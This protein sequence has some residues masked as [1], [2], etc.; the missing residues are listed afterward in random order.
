MEHVNKDIDE[1]TVDILQGDV[2]NEQLDELAANGELRKNVLVGQDII[3]GL[4]RQSESIDVEDRLRRFH[5]THLNR[6]PKRRLRIAAAAIVAVAAAVA[7]LLLIPA[8]NNGE[9]ERME[10]AHFQVADNRQGGIS[11]TNHRGE[12]VVLASKTQQNTSLTLD[13]F[14][15]VFSD[16]EGREDITLHVPVGKSADIALPDGSIAYLHPGSRLL[17][18]ERFAGDV[19]AVKLDGEAYFKVNHDARHPF[20]VISGNMEIT[21]LGTEFN[22]NTQSHEVVLVSGSVKV[23]SKQSGKQ[24]TLKPGYGVVVTDEGNLTAETVSTDP[25]TSWRDG[26]LYFDNVELH[27]IMQSIAANY[28]MRIV[29]R[30]TVAQHLKMRFMFERNKGVGAAIDM[31]NRMKKVHVSC[32]DNCLFVDP[33]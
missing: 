2:T 26:Y 18:P 1:M 13:D 25:Y 27:D 31:M 21:D 10:K 28:N 9:M 7:A 30:D 14:R 24:L 6:H 23:A 3:S 11:I 5:A 16:N 33:M 22:V 15:K 8:T 4:Q 32:Q 29:F 20:V 19:R 12:Q 17:F